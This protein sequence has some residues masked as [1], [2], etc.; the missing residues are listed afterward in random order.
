MAH[1]QVGRGRPGRGT[2][3]ALLDGLPT[4]R[5]AGEALDERH[6]GAEVVRHVERRAGAVWIHHADLD[7]QSSSAGNGVGRNAGRHGRKRVAENKGRWSPA[8]AGWLFLGRSR[9][10]LGGVDDDEISRFPREGRRLPSITR[11]A[12]DWSRVACRTPVVGSSIPGDRHWQLSRFLCEGVESTQC[13][14][15]HHNPDRTLLRHAKPCIGRWRVVRSFRN[16]QAGEAC[17]YV[18][19]QAAGG[20]AVEPVAAIRTGSRCAGRVTGLR[21]PTVSAASASDRRKTTRRRLPR[22][23]RARSFSAASNRRPGGDPWPGPRVPRQEGRSRDR[24]RRTRPG[25]KTRAHSGRA[26]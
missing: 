26:T 11:A 14:T 21:R 6:V 7:H 19:E 15:A 9:V 3:Q 20:L 25:L 17:S 2:A 4:Q 18:N 24:P 12:L 1:R 22:R 23:R 5:R 16:T 8:P 10:V 13:A